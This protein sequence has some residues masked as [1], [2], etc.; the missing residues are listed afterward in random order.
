MEKKTAETVRSLSR[1]LALLREMNANP[2]ASVTSLARS[3]GVPRSTTY[4]LLDT[5]VAMGFVDPTASNDGY[6]LTREVY[7]LSRGF[8]DEEWIEGAWSEM[9]AL[10]KRVIWP[11]DLLSQEG[12]SMVVRRSTHPHS[13]MSIDYGMVG[14]HWPMVESAAGRAYLA[15]CPA[16]ERDLILESYGFDES[17]HKNTLERNLL[18]RSLEQ[19]RELGFGVRVGGMM[20][21]TGSISAPILVNGGVLC[22]I[23]I[24]WIAR[25]LTP[26]RAIA[27][28]GPLLRD[29]A[30]RIA[31]SAAASLLPSSIGKDER[32]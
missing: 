6:A 9:I 23:S 29:T 12:L 20:P 21:K 26:E 7:S 5:L 18:E 24:I 31:S 2:H 8:L 4:R 19:A 1:G 32:G 13:T 22:C 10:T 25:G 16:T 3:I 27:E 14:R 11:V 17:A 28:L 30:T 15:F